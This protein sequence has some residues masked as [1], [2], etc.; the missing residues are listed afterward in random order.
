MKKILF[1]L[2]IL[3]SFGAQSQPTGALQLGRFYQP[4]RP[5][6]Q[7]TGTPKLYVDT[8]IYKSNL[9]HNVLVAGGKEYDIEA[10]SGYCN[11]VSS[12]IKYKDE[13]IKRTYDGKIRAYR[14]TIESMSTSTS[15]GMKISTPTTYIKYVLEDSAT[16][17]ISE[18][19]YKTLRDW[20][21]A[22]TSARNFLDSYKSVKRKNSLILVGGLVTMIGGLVL[23]GSAVNYEG[24]F[25]D[26]LATG[27]A[28]LIGGGVVGTFWGFLGGGANSVKLRRAVAEYNGM[29]PYGVDPN[30]DLDSF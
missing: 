19:D 24:T 13:F 10:V 6:I 27:G 12:F 4:E 16:G 2:F 30:I 1:L 7:L 14:M 29:D 28:V 9:R 8:V 25:A 22:N 23:V 11:G 3:S 21:P 17:R 15:G 26:R 20:I 18:V 5:F